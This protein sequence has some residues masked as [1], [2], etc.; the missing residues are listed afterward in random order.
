MDPDSGAKQ[1]ASQILK[2]TFIIISFTAC[3]NY[4]TETATSLS[5]ISFSLPTTTQIRM[6]R[7]SLAVKKKKKIIYLTFDDGPNKGTQ[8]VIDII[9]AEQIPVTAFVVGEHVYDSKSQKKDYNSLANDPFFEIANHSFTHAHNKY[10]KFYSTPD[11]VVS[12]FIRCADS[13]GLT[14]KIIRTPG[15]NIW[16]MPDISSTDVKASRPAAD[17]LQQKG[18]MAVGWDLEWQFDDQLKLKTSCDEMVKQVDNMFTYSRTHTQNH[19]VILAHD[20]VYADAADSAQLH[21]FIKKLKEKN[22]YDFEMINQYPN[23]CSKE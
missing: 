9:N 14:S 10:A 21:Q 4:K 5:R 16:R 8:H 13:L 2:S 7:E 19:L 18:F 1:S 15:R 12:D 3:N 11:N 6:A 20:Q 17:S 23:L 22:E